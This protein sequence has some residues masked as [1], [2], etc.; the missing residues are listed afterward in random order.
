VHSFN[1]EHNHEINKVVVEH[2]HKKRK[3]DPENE[4]MALEV[5][6]LK[7]N[8]KM[9]QQAL[10]HKTQK[11]VLL[12][13][14]TNLEQRAKKKSPNNL[15]ELLN[16]LN[17]SNRQLEI[18]VAHSKG[19]VQ[20]IMVM[21]P[22]MK[23]LYTNYPELLLM[24]A[25]YKLT[26]DCMALYLLLTID[27]NGESHIVSM[28]LVHDETQAVLQEMVSAF[29]HSFEAEIVEKTKVII[30]DKDFVER[31]VL[32]AS[33]PNAALH[34]CLF[35]TLLTF[36]REVTTAKMSIRTQERET[37]LAILS[38]LAYSRNE[39]EYEDHHQ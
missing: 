14:L 16:H 39:E 19:Q 4:K 9:V 32:R 37:A 26:N 15:Q 34:L 2:H 25:T 3:L 20:S 35:H 10:R 31:N 27:G 24:D 21:D 6:Q 13:D 29:T 22:E 17:G 36:G 12:K 8:K 38:R 5:L 30:T 18:K 7:G 11:R 33:F 23:E 1:C 28:F